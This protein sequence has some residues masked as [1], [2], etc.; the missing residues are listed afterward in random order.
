MFSEK[1][2]H[3]FL[4]SCD[5][6][7]Q[8]WL[9]VHRVGLAYICWRGNVEPPWLRE[10]I[11]VFQADPDRGEEKLAEF[12]A[13]PHYGRGGPDF[14]IS[15]ENRQ[16]IIKMLHYIVNEKPNLNELVN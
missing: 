8:Q 12:L 7:G 1:D 13:E 16:R 3:E 14:V 9:Q 2:W 6:V 11:R 10:V 15:E 4:Y 5:L